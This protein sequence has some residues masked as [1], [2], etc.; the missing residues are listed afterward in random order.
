M[1]LAFMKKFSSYGLYLCALLLS[2]A[3]DALAA[4]I[5]VTRITNWTTIAPTSADT[6]I[7]KNGATNTVDAANG[8]CAGIDIGSDVGMVG[9]RGI[10]T[11]AFNSNSQVMVGK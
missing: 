10:G 1:G 11:L 6:V 5:N 2:W 4:T 9:Q 3:S 8:E 7:T